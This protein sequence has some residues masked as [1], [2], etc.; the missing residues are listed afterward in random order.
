M[1]MILTDSMLD[2]AFKFR[3]TEPWAELDDS[4]LFSAIL[5]DGTQVYCSI[6]GHGGKHHSLSIYVGSQGFATFLLALEADKKN[7][8]E[9]LCS[10][11]EFDCINCD[12]MQ[13]K[14]IRSEVKKTIRDY[15]ERHS[16][17]IPRKF[18]W[19]DFTRHSPFYGS[20]CITDEHDAFVAEETLRAATFFVQ[21]FHE[22]SFAEVH[23]DLE[24]NY[25]TRDGGKLIPLITTDESGTYQISTTR[26]PRTEKRDYPAFTFDNDILRHQLKSLDQHDEW[27]CRMLHFPTPVHNKDSEIPVLPGALVM[28]D[29]NGGFMH[30]PFVTA[31]YPDHSKKLF[32][33]LADHIAHYIGF[34]P[35]KIEVSDDKTFYMMDDFCRKCGV[36]LTKVKHMPMMD[37][38]CMALMQN[39][40]MP[41]PM[42]NM[43]LDF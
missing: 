21:R 25:P 38:A 6:M 8:I 36:Q 18:G 35:K 23:L 10:S 40:L 20:W 26:T 31:D 2:A 24:G 16:L 28:V 29:K 9:A 32:E 17:K 5:S 15:A 22:T 39:I 3:E 13:A 34:L 14:G 37:E 30:T 27:Q 43:M 33:E 7:A 19:I 11:S 4:N 41:N 42:M 1:K 12:F